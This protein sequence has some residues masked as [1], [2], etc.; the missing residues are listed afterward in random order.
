MGG[1]W[2]LGSWFSET[3]EGWTI[4]DWTF[5]GIVTVLFVGAYVYWVV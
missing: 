5:Y 1:G 2:S 4:W 3:T